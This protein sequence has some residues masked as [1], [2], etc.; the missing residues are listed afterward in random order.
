MLCWSV[1]GQHWLLQE[2]YIALQ[3]QG[4]VDNFLGDLDRLLLVRLQMIQEQHIQRH[5]IVLELVLHFVDELG[6]LPSVPLWLVQRQHMLR[7][8]I[9]L[10]H[11][12][13]IERKLVV[14]H[15]P[16]LCCALL[17]YLAE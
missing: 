11:F 12:V 15:F 9:P 6:R 4:L 16:G 1:L 5:C 10:V 17:P 13:G 8:Y 7:Q 2:L 14:V 3:I